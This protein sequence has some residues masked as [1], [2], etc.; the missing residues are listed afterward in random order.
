MKGSQVGLWLATR[1]AINTAI[2]FEVMASLVS[3]LK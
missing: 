1:A 2:A 3:T